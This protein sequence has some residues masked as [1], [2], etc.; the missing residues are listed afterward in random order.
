MAVVFHLITPTPFPSPSA[1]LV[2]TSL[3]FFSAKIVK[4]DNTP[5]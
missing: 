4:Y 2:K 3:H 1:H 5:S